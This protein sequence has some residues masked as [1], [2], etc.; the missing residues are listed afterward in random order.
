MS[1]TDGAATTSFLL[2]PRVD[3]PGRYWMWSLGFGVFLL[4]V[5]AFR[6]RCILPNWSI[7]FLG[8]AAMELGLSLGHLA[9]LTRAELTSTTLKTWKWWS[10]GAAEVADLSTATSVVVEEQRKV[11]FAPQYA[12]KIAFSDRPEQ[13]LGWWGPFV[14]RRRVKRR[15][16]VIANQIGQSIAQGDES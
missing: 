13:R 12:L 5:Y 10:F 9:S 14:D 4:F 8:L 1:V 15:F 2:P 16:E 11:F 3:G 7:P 6:G